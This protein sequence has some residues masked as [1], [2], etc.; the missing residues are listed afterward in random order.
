[1]GPARG[2]ETALP[3]VRADSTD[4]YINQI[5]QAQQ[6]TNDYV[7]QIYQKQQQLND[8]LNQVWQ[9]QQ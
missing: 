3:G 4:D 6:Q 1:V 7:N 9:T 8:Y 5:Y 2:V